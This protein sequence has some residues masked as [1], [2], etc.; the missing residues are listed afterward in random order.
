M[1][2]PELSWPSFAAKI[3][4]GVILRLHVFHLL[5]SASRNSTDLDVSSPPPE[6]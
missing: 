6:R 2:D 1:L 4:A 5:Q 3:E